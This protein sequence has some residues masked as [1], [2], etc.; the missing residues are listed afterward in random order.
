MYW[1]SSNGGLIVVSS[2]QRLK[3]DFDYDL[4]GIET[5]KKLTPVRFTWKESEK[6]Q[7]GFVA[8]EAITADEHLAWNDTENDQWGL[9]GW[10]GYVAMLTKAV[11]EL[12]A[13]VESLKEKLNG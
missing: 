10:E 11:Q 7:L 4:S 12:S 8:Q 2:D 9:N 3:K 13:E 1:N 6:R 5:I